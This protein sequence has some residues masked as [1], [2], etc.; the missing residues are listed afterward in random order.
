MD[1]TSIN[2]DIIVLSHSTVGDRNGKF[3]IYQGEKQNQAGLPCSNSIS[4]YAQKSTFWP[5]NIV[6]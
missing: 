6:H 1:K 4:V 3:L 2:S 5:K